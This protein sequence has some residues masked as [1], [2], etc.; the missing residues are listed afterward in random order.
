MNLWT[1]ELEG[2][3]NKEES[4][5]EQY[6]NNTNNKRSKSNKNKMDAC[7]RKLNSRGAKLTGN[8][9][10]QIKRWD[11]EIVRCEGNGCNYKSREE[12]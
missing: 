9:E 11:C 6:Y 2:K 7:Q 5:H 12:K 1:E 10:K 4:H 8:E 3:L